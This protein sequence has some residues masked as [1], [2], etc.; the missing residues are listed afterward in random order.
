MHIVRT[1]AKGIGWSLLLSFLALVIWA[2]WEEKP[3][4]AKVK[5]ISMAIFNAG[6]LETTAAATELDQ[7][8]EQL[9][10]VTAC[11]ANPESRLV[12]V[13]YD[14]DQLTEADLKRHIQQRFKHVAKP[15][16][17]SVE[18]SGPQCPIPAEYIQKLEQFKYAL[19][20][21]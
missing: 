13:T 11:T 12:A 9:P 1:T 3:L 5:P 7:R 19:N 4:H 2:N 8:L 20:F 16:F 10:G 17:E 21:R 18:P 15:S 6:D 14:P